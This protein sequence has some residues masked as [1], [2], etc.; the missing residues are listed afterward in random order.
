M[1]AGRPTDYREEYNEQAYKLALLGAKDTEI[2]DFFEVSEVTLN[3]WKKK[4]PKFLKSLKAGKQEADMNIAEK[5]YNR[6]TGFKLTK[7]QAIKYKI[8]KDLEE[9][10]VVDL[11]EEIPPD[12]TS[13]IFWL[14]NR[15]SGK[16]SDKQQIDHTITAPTI[17][18]DID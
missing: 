7:Q 11:E 8:G 15:Q 2:A 3:A 13:M 9:I 4:H 5:L 17:A 12:T 6:A 10:K 16:W 1:G 14:K 18:D